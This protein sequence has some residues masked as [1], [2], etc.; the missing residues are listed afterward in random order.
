MTMDRRRGWT[1]L[2]VYVA[3]ALSGLTCTDGPTAPHAAHGGR[4]GV[5]LMPEF[6]S[7]A[8]VAYQA[9]ADVGMGVDN[10]HIHIVHPPAAPFDTIVAFPAGAD[11]I[12]LALQ[13]QLNA[14]TEQLDATVELRQG[15]SVLFSGTQSLTASVGVTNP[16]P[17]P[18]VLGYVGPG[19]TAT[20]FTIAPRD[21][22]IPPTG[23]ATFR[24]TATDANNANVTGIPVEWG[25]ADASVGTITSAGV[26]TPAVQTGATFVI[27]VTLNGLR[28]STP[29]AIVPP[30]T[31]LVLV[32]G[33]NQTGTAGAALA[34][35][36]ICRHKPP[37]ER[38]GVA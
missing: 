27:G 32:S 25:V 14:P 13:I 10:V 5:N 23:S 21:T 4:A 30:P 33:G 36:L 19:A 38:S 11:S 26:F 20:Q 37:T 6:S 31:K 18:I 1:R 35:P 22:T 9:L 24:F 29:I 34:Q 8:L 3:I 2:L 17:P 12:V 15:D 7:A 28:D 16:A